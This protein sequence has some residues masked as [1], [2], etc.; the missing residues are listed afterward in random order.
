MVTSGTSVAGYGVPYL[1][2]MYRLLEGGVGRHGVQEELV[3]LQS[4]H[5]LATRL[6]LNACHVL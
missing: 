5:E 2:V 6:G 4:S 3:E 1:G